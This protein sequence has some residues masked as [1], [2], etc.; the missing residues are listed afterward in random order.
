MFR[1]LVL[2][3][4]LLNVKGRQGFTLICCEFSSWFHSIGFHSCAWTEGIIETFLLESKQG[5]QAKERQECLGEH[6]ETKLQFA[7]N[8]STYS[9]K[10]QLE[11]YIDRCLR[12]VQ[13]DPSNVLDVLYIGSSFSPRMSYRIVIQF[14]DWI[15]Y[16][17]SYIMS[18]IS[19]T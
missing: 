3:L 4:W 18:W 15:S 7:S 14:L 9:Q 13:T 11:D 10:S 2:L 16:T 17:I 12:T 8:L 19:Y 1:C 5:C 6:S